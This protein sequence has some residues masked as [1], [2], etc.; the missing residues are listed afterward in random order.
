MYFLMKCE[1][2]LPQQSTHLYKNL[3]W[4]LCH[5]SVIGCSALLHHAFPPCFASLP[6]GSRNMEPS[7]NGLKHQNYYDNNQGFALLCVSWKA[8]NRNWNDII[9]CLFLSGSHAH[10]WDWEKCTLSLSHHYVGLGVLSRMAIW[11]SIKNLY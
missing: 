8:K 11:E 6:V 3:R 7:N 4:S 1:I 9:L 10:S 5:L 2:F